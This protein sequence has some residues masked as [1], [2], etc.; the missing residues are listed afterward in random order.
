MFHKNRLKTVASRQ[1]Q[2]DVPRKN[3][4]QSVSIGDFA[5]SVSYI[6]LRSKKEVE[7]I[8]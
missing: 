3:K 6:L 8:I 1:E 7:H 4:F 5:R 2:T